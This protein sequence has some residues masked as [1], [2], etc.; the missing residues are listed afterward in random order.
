MEIGLVM[1][2]FNKRGSDYVVK[3]I[4]ATHGELADGLRKSVEFIMGDRKSLYSIPAYTDN[5]LDPEKTINEIISGSN[6]PIICFTDIFGG[7]INNYIMSTLSIH[8]NIHLITGVNLPMII[9]L[10]MDLDQDIDI[11]EAIDNCINSGQ[12]GIFECK[13]NKNNDKVFDSF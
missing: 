6:E 2:P 3:V 9:Q 8:S 4:I 11:E 7:S 12:N 10:L 5:C 13:K 1:E